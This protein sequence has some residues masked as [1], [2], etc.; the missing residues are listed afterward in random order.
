[1]LYSLTSLTKNFLLSKFHTVSR[2]TRQCNFADAHKTIAATHVP[3][4]TTLAL[5]NSIMCR[6]LIYHGYS[7]PRPTRLWYAARG[8]ICQLRVSSRSLSYAQPLPKRVRHIVRSSASSCDLQCFLVSL[9]SSSSSTKS[10]RADSR[11]KEALQRF[12]D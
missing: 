10:S 12:R 3:I 8:R 9:R 5:L 1:M 2:N 4:P 7:N 11:V 6:S